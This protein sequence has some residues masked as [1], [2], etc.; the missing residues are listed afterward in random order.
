MFFIYTLIIA[1]I[2]EQFCDLIT[3]NQNLF[4]VSSILIS[5]KSFWGLS[6]SNYGLY[7]APCILISF[8]II[9]SNIF[10]KSV[11][12][13][14]CFLLIAMSLQ[15]GV[16]NYF[17]IKVA[18]Y[19]IKSEKGTIYTHKEMGGAT[20]K[21]IQYIN[22][23]KEENPSVM[24][25]P[26]GLMLN[27]LADKKTKTNGFYSSLIPLYTEGFGEDR[28]IENLKESPIDY[29]IFSNI[30]SESYRKGEICATYAHN[31]CH[32]IYNNYSYLY[33]TGDDEKYI[34]TVFK[35]N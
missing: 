2:C 18:N 29:I 21:A 19:P 34:Y 35:R 15:Y 4:I 26:E 6:H 11:T 28:I 27:F 25:Y 16:D 7:F 3:K 13:S 12:K 23:L 32:Y 9:C 1:D 22:G 33:K 14:L 17:G 8:F 24:V 31:I 5:M 10:S 30:L 20:F